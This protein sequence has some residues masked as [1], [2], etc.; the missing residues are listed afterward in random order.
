MQLFKR[1]LNKIV[2][3]EVCYIYPFLPCYIQPVGSCEVG[4]LYSIKEER[5]HSPGFKETSCFLFV[6]RS[7]G[8]VLGDRYSQCIK[9]LG[10]GSFEVDEHIS[11]EDFYLHC[12]VCL[13][14]HLYV[15]FLDS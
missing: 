5:S 14:P 11:T 10:T 2:V 12:F 6:W 13:S 8:T 4:R 7:A 15:V 3:T 9:R 1:D